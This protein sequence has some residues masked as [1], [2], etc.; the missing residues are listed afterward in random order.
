MK[1]IIILSGTLCLLGSYS[2]NATQI[3]VAIGLPVYESP[4][5]VI[6]PDY[7]SYHYDHHR[8]PHNDYWAHRQQQEHGHNEH[9]HANGNH[10]EEN[11]AHR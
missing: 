11:H 8:H 6:A 2:A 4:G 5:Y 9:A 10:A 7:P 1:K 3:S